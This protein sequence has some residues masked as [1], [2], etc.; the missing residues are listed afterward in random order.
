MRKRILESRKAAMELSIGT[1]V[2]IVLGV[3]MLI[4]GIFLINRLRGSA[5]NV[6]DMADDAITKE[7]NELF[8]EPKKVAIYPSTKVAKIDQEEKDDVGIV[9][10]NLIQ[11]GT[12]SE[13][14]SYKVELSDKGNC[15]ET[16]E[17]INS[18]ITLGREN[19][20][21]ESLAPGDSTVERVTFT[22]PTTASLCR[23]RFN[24]AVFV[25][26]NP[27]GRESFDVEIQPK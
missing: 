23:A 25:D 1:I 5:T 8:T 18:W 17:Q 4:V 22:I 11:G 7:L 15:V 14:F 26:G 3:S 10:T 24:V 2:I 27:Y 6:I 20:N 13:I 19:L 12:G 21:I 9:I 16:E